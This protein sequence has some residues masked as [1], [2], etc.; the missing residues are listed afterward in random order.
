MIKMIP[1]GVSSER[2]D[3]LGLPICPGCGQRCDSMMENAYPDHVRALGCSRCNL[4]NVEG[5]GEP[6]I[7]GKN[8]AMILAER[9]VRVAAVRAAHLGYAEVTS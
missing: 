8:G 3:Q 1:Y 7:P 2:A 4:V 9:A 6:W 5:S